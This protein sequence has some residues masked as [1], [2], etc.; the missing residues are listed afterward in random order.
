VSIQEEFALAW[1]PTCEQ[2]CVPMRNGTCGF[3]DTPVKPLPPWE[4]SAK[5]KRRRRTGLPRRISDADLHKLHVLHTQAKKLSALELARKVYVR[6]GYSSP[7][8]CHAAI[9][10]GWKTLGL[11]ARDRIEMTVE[12]STKN[13][14]SPRNWTDRRRRRLAAGLTNKGRVRQPRCPAT[15]ARGKRCTHRSM[16][17][18]FCWAHDPARAE[19]RSRQLAA[20]RAKSPIC[21]REY[22]P[23]E[24]VL[25][26]LRD[27]HERGY[28]WEEIGVA[29]GLTASTL[30]TYMVPSRKAQRCSTERASRIRA[31][32]ASLDSLERAA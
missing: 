32:L 27:A 29:V 11:K 19:E 3:C 28:S 23:W 1:C 4:M 7:Q 12:M 24:P 14:L 18:G 25:A 2:K 6:F 21:M 22:V 13:G 26:E 31:G 17:S 8:A 5:G 15:T 20:M 10:S 30:K 9:L 16:P